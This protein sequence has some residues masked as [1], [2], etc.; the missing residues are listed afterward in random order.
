MTRSELV[1][2]FYGMVA[3]A[4]SECWKLC[5]QINDALSDTPYEDLDYSMKQ[6]LTN[7]LRSGSR[8]ASC[9]SQ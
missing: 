5:M 7:I 3:L 6:E 2:S 4:F 1:Q 9:M 8:L